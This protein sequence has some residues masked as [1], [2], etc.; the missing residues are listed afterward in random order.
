MESLKTQFRKETE[1]TYKLEFVLSE[2]ADKENI[3]IEK[4]DLDKLFVNI[5]DEKERKKA[6]QNS[7]YYA[8]ILRKQKTL[9]YLISL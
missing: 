2:I 4:T 7:Y 8:T 9:D 5:K 1:D 6:E 3:K